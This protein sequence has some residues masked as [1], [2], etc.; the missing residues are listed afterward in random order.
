MI[1]GPNECS[2]FL[3]KI[4]TE[5]TGTGEGEHDGHSLEARKALA[6]KIDKLNSR[7]NER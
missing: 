2:L 1:S 6:T 3:V 5:N 4:I 7:G